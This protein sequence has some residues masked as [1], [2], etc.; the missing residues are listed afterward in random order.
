MSIYE[1]C[2]KRH[3]RRVSMRVLAQGIAA[4]GDLS[5]LKSP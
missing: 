2:R 3:M 4:P 5:D 1:Q